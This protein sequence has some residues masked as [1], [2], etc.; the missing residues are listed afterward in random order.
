MKFIQVAEK[1]YIST[2]QGRSVWHSRKEENW[3]TSQANSNEST[4]S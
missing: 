3:I 4:Y 2:E 1:Y